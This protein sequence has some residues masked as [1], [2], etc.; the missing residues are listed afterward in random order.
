MDLEYS[1]MTTTWPQKMLQFYQD[2]LS[3]DGLHYT[4]QVGR[5]SKTFPIDKTKDKSKDLVKPYYKGYTV[6]AFF[7][8]N[9]KQG[10]SYIG[11]YWS[12]SFGTVYSARV[13]VNDGVVKTEEHQTTSNKVGVVNPGD[14]YNVALRTDDEVNFTMSFNRQGFHKANMKEITNYW[15]FQLWEYTGN[16]T[17][18][19][20]HFYNEGY[21]ATPKLGDKY[22]LYLDDFLVTVG[23]SGTYVLEY[24][25]SNEAVTV[26]VKGESEKLEF[27]FANNGRLRK[28]DIFYCVVR[29][30][31]HGFVVSTSFDPKPQFKRAK[32][33]LTISLMPCSF[34]KCSIRKAHIAS[35]A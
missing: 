22:N 24:D 7:F 4:F 34:S 2:V 16:H 20:M 30:T 26:Y 10:E 19:S 11:A 9:Q 8:A 31:A 6:R 32:E 29:I 17:T 21:G 18:L 25:G 3:K 5:S 15:T 28:K 13:V 33:L 1:P 12:N 35:F 27:T 23:T 14:I